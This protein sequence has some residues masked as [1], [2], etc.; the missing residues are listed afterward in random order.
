MHIGSS[1]I[2]DRLYQPGNHFTGIT[3]A[4]THCDK[5]HPAFQTL[6]EHRLPFEVFEKCID[7]TYTSGHT[8]NKR[9]FRAGTCFTGTHHALTG[10]EMS[11]PRSTA[12]LWHRLPSATDTN[13]KT[14]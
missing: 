1:I 4:H 12:S 9:L 2:K 5:P 13:G 7:I 3:H 8:V 11:L 14:P 10:Q 6:Q